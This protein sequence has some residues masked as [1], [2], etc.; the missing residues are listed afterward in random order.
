LAQ[1]IPVTGMLM[2]FSAMA[3]SR[4]LGDLSNLPGSREFD[5]LQGR[6][7]LVQVGRL[8]P[9]YGDLLFL[10]IP[11]NLGNP[12]DLPQFFLNGHD[13]MAAVDVRN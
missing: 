3:Q 6:F 1:L 2:F 11:F 13:T 9:F 7:D 8:I 12:L 4:I 5:L 10:W